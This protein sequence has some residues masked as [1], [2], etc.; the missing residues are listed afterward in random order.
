MASAVTDDGSVRMNYNRYVQ[1]IVEMI[2][3][4]RLK[5]MIWRTKRSPEHR[6]SIPGGKKTAS[7]FERPRMLHSLD[8][9]S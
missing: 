3:R 4:E 6:P 8:Y 9:L 7:Y 2:Y 5:G 1:D